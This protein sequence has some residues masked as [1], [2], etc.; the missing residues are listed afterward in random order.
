MNLVGYTKLNSNNDSYLYG[1]SAIEFTQNKVIIL[2]HARQDFER[3]IVFN[4]KS[5]D[6]EYGI[7]KQGQGPEEFYG[8]GDI[9]LSRDN[10][11]II[12]LVPGT[13]S[14]ISY[15]L[16]GKFLSRTQTD[17]FGDEFAVIGKNT[18]AVYNEYMSCLLYTSPS[19]RD[20]TLSRMPS[21]A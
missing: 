18:F 7:G 4:K 16:D 19:P 14:I 5:G 1:V 6:F 3:I 10:S 17:M 13:M 12:G 11:S 8:I 2:D 21:S 9:Q 20:A 15:S